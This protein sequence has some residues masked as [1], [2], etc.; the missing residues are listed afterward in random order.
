VTTLLERRRLFLVVIAA[1]LADLVTFLA[2]ISRVGIHAEQNPV[3]RGLFGSLGSAGP[4]AYKV[5]AI[6]LIVLVLWRI[7]VRFPG[8]AGR[9]GALAI[10]VGL[11]GAW[12]NIAFGLAR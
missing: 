1:Q 10:A 12:S 8:Y 4:T 3:A 6:G 9:S 5:V 2:A 11:L 7:A